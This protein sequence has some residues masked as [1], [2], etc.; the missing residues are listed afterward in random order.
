M[1]LFVQRVLFYSCQMSPWFHLAPSGPRRPWLLCWQHLGT[2]KIFFN[3]N[4]LLTKFIFIII[5]WG[6][7]CIA[8]VSRLWK[9]EAANLAAVGEGRQHALLLLSVAKVLH[10]AQV[11]GVVSAHNHAGAMWR[12]K[13]LVLVCHIIYLYMQEKKMLIW[14][15]SSEWIANTYRYQ[16]VL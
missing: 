3:L 16:T 9:A 6:P 15:F 13:P 10:R 7:T 12:K 14:H 4:S 5:T 2:K 1:S 8:T 11:Q